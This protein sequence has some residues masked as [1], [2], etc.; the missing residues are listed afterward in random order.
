MNDTGQFPVLHSKDELHAAISAGEKEFVRAILGTVHPS[1]I[2]DLLESLPNK[3]VD[4]IWPLIDPEIVGDVLSQVQDNIRSR[5]LEQMQPHEVVE[6][7]KDL[8][9]DDLAD[10]IQD[11][12]ENIQD[13]VLLSMDELNR[14]RLASLLSYPEDTAG[15]LMSTDVVPVRTDATLAT[16]A[17]YLRFLGHRD[18]LPTQTDNLMVID[19]NNIYLGVLPLMNIM[20]REQEL[21]VGEVM[22]AEA[23]IPAGETT[24]DVATVFEQRD[25]VSAAVVDDNGLLLGRITID[26]V[27]D[28]IQEEAESAVRSMAGVRDEDI[29]APIISSTK[30]R[31]VWLGI[32]LLTAFLAAWVIGRFEASIEQLV[33]LAVLMPIVASMGG[34][35]GGQTLTI[36]IRGIA[37][38]H[39]GRRNIRHL[40]VKELIVGLINGLIWASVVGLVATLWFGD[41]QLGMIIGLAMVINLV[42]AALAGAAIPLTLKRLGVDP[43]VAGGVILTTITDVV[44]FLTFLGLAT[45]FLIA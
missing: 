31:A 14:Q 2:A 12:P 41:K 33:A 19:R 11:L 13:S 20:T 32:N 22:I 34:I 35:A 3:E 45:R 24:H 25:W 16:V 26:D 5:L 9:D 44:G 37:V 6:V 43:A 42:V 39:V 7:T 10:I 38:G 29:F 27:V 30:T 21:S 15:G 18:E 23:G 40:M 36:A 28:V 1:E 4:F 17:R 8:E